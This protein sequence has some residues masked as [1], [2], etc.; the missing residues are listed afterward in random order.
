MTTKDHTSGSSEYDPV[1]HQPR[2]DH[3]QQ[4]KALRDEA[5]SH[6]DPVPP[7]AGEYTGWDRQG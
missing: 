7:I 5:R 6:D 2:N 1:P 4:L 3:D